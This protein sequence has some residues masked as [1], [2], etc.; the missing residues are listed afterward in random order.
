M[1]NLDGYLNDH[2]AGSIGALELV[3][4]LID[5]YEGKP[6]EQFFRDLRDKIDQDQKTLKQLIEDL[7][8]KESAIR[9]AGAWVLEKFSRARIQLSESGE[10]EMGLFLALE[11][12]AL[13]I[14]GKRYLWR[15]LAFAAAES[16]ALRKL[17]YA[18]LEKRAIEQCDEVE[19]KRMEVA[20]RVLRPA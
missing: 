9:K 16:V 18:L 1:E 12:L 2:L 20:R 10:E 7:G 15:A 6:R 3:D 17:D 19:A 4:R 8:E 5:V 13:G 14:T 11:A